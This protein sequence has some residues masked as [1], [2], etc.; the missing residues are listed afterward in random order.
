MRWSPPASP[1]RPTTG[2]LRVTQVRSAIGTKP[3][4]RGT[5][6]ALGLRGIGRTNVLP[7]RPE[8]RG[9]LA[10]VPHLVE[11]EPVRTRRTAPD[12]GPRAP[13]AGGLDPAQAPGRPRHRRQGRQDRRPRYQGPG[14]PRH[15]PARLRGRPAPADAAHPQAA[16]VQEPV[17]GRVHPGQPRRPGRPG[18]GRGRPRSFWWRVGLVRKGELVK[19]LGGGELDPAR[20]GCRPT[21]SRSRRRRPSPVPVAPSTVVPLPFGHGRPPAQGNALTNR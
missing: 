11:V 21:P 19:V 14:R 7:D 16:R 10:R 13:P 17:P 8:I 6:R 12:E 20:S 5:L 2:P 15:H 4:H 1:S 3:K 9:M 18:G